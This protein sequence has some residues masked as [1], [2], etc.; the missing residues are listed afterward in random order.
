MRKTV[1]Q[2]AQFLNSDQKMAC[3][4]GHAV[5]VQAYISGV[6]HNCAVQFYSIRASGSLLHCNAC[7]YI[8]NALC[9]QGVKN[10]AHYIYPRI[11]HYQRRTSPAHA[12]PRHKHRGP[13]REPRSAHAAGGGGGGRRAQQQT[14][15]PR[16]WPSSAAAARASG[17][18]APSPAARAA[19]GRWSGGS[20]DGGESSGG[21][22]RVGRR[23]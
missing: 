2:P 17:G 20:G 21:G 12:G 15:S 11:L 23:G 9:M 16:R 19:A 7:M 8:C 4:G 6:Y 1:P 13:R 3:P 18:S 10:S 14:C 5:S 22:G